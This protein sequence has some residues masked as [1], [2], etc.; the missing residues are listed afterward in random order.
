VWGRLFRTLD[1][2]VQWNWVII[3]A[4]FGVVTLLFLA[5]LRGQRTQTWFLVDILRCSWLDHM[6]CNFCCLVAA[7]CNCSNEC[8]DATCFRAILAIVNHLCLAVRMVYSVLANVGNWES[9]YYLV[10][11]MHTFH[12]GFNIYSLTSLQ[13]CLLLIGIELVD[14]HFMELV[15]GKLKH[16][17]FQFTS[18]PMQNNRRWTLVICKGIKQIFLCLYFTMH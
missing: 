3:Y 13:T 16:D 2:T 14:F 12:V 6:L 8:F 4:L 15:F 11:G 7:A 17:W 5:L 10:F 18:W 1:E 9:W